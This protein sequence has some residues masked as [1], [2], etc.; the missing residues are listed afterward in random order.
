MS[1]TFESVPQSDE[2]LADM[3]GLKELAYALEAH[4]KWAETVPRYRTMALEHLE[5]AVMLANK[6]IARREL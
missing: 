3:D 1:N 5:I 6:G 2:Q 4:I